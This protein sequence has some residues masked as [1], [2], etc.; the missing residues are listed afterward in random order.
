M[1][2][3]ILVS[4]A[5]WKSGR[6]SDVLETDGEE[7]GYRLPPPVQK[8][9]RGHAELVPGMPRLPGCRVIW[10]LPI[11]VSWSSKDL[12]VSQSSLTGESDAIEKR[13]ELGE[14]DTPVRAVWSN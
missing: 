8:D 14:Q 11:S 3:A 2:S 5:E 12:F 13:A 9:G 1:L 6:A 4:C 10:C 7:Y